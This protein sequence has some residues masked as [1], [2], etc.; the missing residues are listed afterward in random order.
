MKKLKKYKKLEILK[1]NP[2]NKYE[3]IDPIKLL[4]DLVICGGANEVSEKI[5][6]LK[7]EIGKF[8]TITYVGIDWKEPLL[9]KKSMILMGTKVMEKIN[10]K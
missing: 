4:R 2:D 5:L 6:R 8:D 10:K 7:N 1:K 3:K 9:A